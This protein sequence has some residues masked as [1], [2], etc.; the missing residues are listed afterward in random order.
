MPWKQFL[1]SD[2]PSLVILDKKYD[3]N[4]IPVWILL[5][6]QGK[7]I[8]RHMGFEGGANGLDVQVRGL[9]K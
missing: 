6:G 2:S 5:D 7:L 1:T 9:I 3:L 4:A 8:K